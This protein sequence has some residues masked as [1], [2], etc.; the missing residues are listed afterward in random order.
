[1]EIDLRTNKETT[2]QEIKNYAE[3]VETLNN[4][5]QQYQVQIKRS[6][7][8][9]TGEL[10]ISKARIEALTT[11]NKNLKNSIEK[12]QIQLDNLK[13]EHQNQNDKLEKKIED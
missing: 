2:E 10:Q 1:M 7:D 9:S 4:Q 12:R 5:V 8:N 13:S 6:T 3:K 11:E